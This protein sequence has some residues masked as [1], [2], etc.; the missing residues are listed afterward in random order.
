MQFYFVRCTKI[1]IPK[2]RP[3]REKLHINYASAVTVTNS[4]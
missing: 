2:M 3:L 1:I 4:I